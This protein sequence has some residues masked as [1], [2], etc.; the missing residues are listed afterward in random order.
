MAQELGLWFREAAPQ[1]SPAPLI[2]RPHIK[3][4]VRSIS[5]CLSSLK[6]N[7]HSTAAGTVQS[8]PSAPRI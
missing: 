4:F 5:L 3:R 1:L 8:P 2:R 7:S 6:R